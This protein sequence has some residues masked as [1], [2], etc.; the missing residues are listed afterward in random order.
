MKLQDME[1]KNT[2]T[3]IK[4]KMDAANTIAK[5]QLAAAT[6]AGDKIKG[7]GKAV[8]THLVSSIA[9]AFENVGSLIDNYTS[10]YQKYSA[11]INARLQTFDDQSGKAFKDL[12]ALV[13]KNLAASP[14]IK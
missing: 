6:N 9:G 5:M 14:Y 7:A 3:E 12:N 8:A 4:N 1:I 2:A 10:T 11:S 13:K